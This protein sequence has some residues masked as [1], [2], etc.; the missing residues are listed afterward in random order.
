MRTKLRHIA[1]TTPAFPGA[2]VCSGGAMRLALTPQ[3]A[4]S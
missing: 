2:A 3:Q 1:I 4:A